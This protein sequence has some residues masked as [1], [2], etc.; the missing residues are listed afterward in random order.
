MS[1]AQSSEDPTIYQHVKRPQWGIAL[2]SW[3]GD[4]RRTFLF[5]DGQARTIKADYY[6]MMGEVSQLPEGA[7]A[8][9]SELTEK[10]E[11]MRTRRVE[12]RPAPERAKPT[13]TFD[14]QVLVLRKEY[15]GGFDDP[16][17]I[18]TVRGEV[19]GRKTKKLRLPAM[20]KAQ[21][22]LARET[23]DAMVAEE[24]YNGVRD[25]IV[26]VL[27]GTDLVRPPEILPIAELKDEEARGL[28][29]AA[30]DLLYGE[31]A[32]EARFTRWLAALPVAEKSSW[33]LATALPALLTPDDQVCVR[34]TSFRQQARYFDPRLEYEARPSAR[35]YQRLLELVRMVLA[36]LKKANEN[37]RDLMDAYDFIR[38]TLRPRAVRLSKEIVE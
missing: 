32:Y 6:S 23:L 22:R 33:P 7:E 8:I 18:S 36:A 29:L 26:A 13:M 14:Q 3:E 28:A 16:T 38:L 34:P 31:E 20:N 35:L 12:R 37:P 4:D 19:G 11:V 2:L 15:P 25:A 27:K 10:V 30:V 17:W 1:R 24:N 21:E 5:Q 9:L